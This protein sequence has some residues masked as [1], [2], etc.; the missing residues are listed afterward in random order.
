MSPAQVYLELSSQYDSMDRVVGS[1][2]CMCVLAMVYGSGGGGV[3]CRLRQGSSHAFIL[4]EMT[5]LA[6]G[7]DV[8]LPCLIPHWNFACTSPCVVVVLMET[9]KSCSAA[10]CVYPWGGHPKL[11][12][13]VSRISPVMRSNNFSSSSSIWPSIQC[14]YWCMFP[15]LLC[16]PV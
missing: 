9:W 8:V 16:V 15:G 7:H 12:S 4:R 1:A 13:D 11:R 2:L 14:W 3:V 6:K 5:A 10:H